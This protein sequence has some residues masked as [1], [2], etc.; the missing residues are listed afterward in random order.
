MRL[1]YSARSLDDVF[2]RAEL[3]SVAA[4]DAAAVFITLTGDSPP[5][6]TGHRGRVD[7][8]LLGEVGWPPSS[9][10]PRCYVCGPTPFVEAVAGALVAIGHEPT[11]VKT[12]RFGPSGG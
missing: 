4:D 12:E 10:G 2:F 5:T 3:D 11:A 9:G 6:W 8:E 1:V 7:G